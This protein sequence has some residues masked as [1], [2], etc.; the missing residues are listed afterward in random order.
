LRNFKLSTR[1]RYPLSQLAFSIIN[2]RQQ[3]RKGNKRCVDWVG[4][5]KTAFVCRWY[6]ENSKESTKT[7]YN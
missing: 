6:I 7:S 2:P 5:N 4:R 3:K 1:Q